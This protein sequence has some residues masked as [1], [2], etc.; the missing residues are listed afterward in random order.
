[1]LYTP[2]SNKSN[3]YVLNVEPGNTVF[4]KTYK[5]EFDNINTTIT[6]HYGRLLELEDK[7]DLT[8][9]IKK[10]KWDSLDLRTRKCVKEYV[11]LTSATKKWI[12]NIVNKTVEAKGKLIGNKTADKII[13]QKPA[14]KAKQSHVEVI[15]IT[16]KQWQE[17]PNYLRLV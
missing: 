10:H 12:K 11:F 8:F 2:T 15:C 1:M 14:P 6:D 7:T 4:F 13:E 5:S 9:F 16:P 3:A 17:L